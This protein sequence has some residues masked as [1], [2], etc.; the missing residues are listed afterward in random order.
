MNKKNIV[1]VIVLS[2]LLNAIILF[3]IFIHFIHVLEDHKHDVCTENST[4]FHKTKSDCKICDFNI[5]TYVYET[6]PKVKHKAIITHKPLI[7]NPY[8]YFYS[9]KYKTSKKLRAPPYKS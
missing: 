6:I 2:S 4:H 3:P 5:T 1:K 7:S 9:T 8:N